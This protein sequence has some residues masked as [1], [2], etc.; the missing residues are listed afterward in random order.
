[1]DKSTYQ[2]PEIYR[3]LQ[4]S[5]FNSVLTVA[6]CGSKSITNRALLLATLAEGE[7]TLRGALFSDDSRH[8]LKCI[9]DLGFESTAD[10]KAR[11]ITVKGCGGRVPLEKANQYVGSAG[12][13]ARFLTAY[14]GVSE[15]SYY[16]DASKQMRKR[17]MAPLLDSLRELGCEIIYEDT[18]HEGFFPFT[19]RGHGFGKNEITVDIAHSSQFLS[20]LLIASCL[21]KE[22]FTTYIE[23]THGRS[24]IDM[25]VK[26]MEQF[27]VKATPLFFCGG[28]SDNHSCTGCINSTLPMGYRTAAGQS[29]RALDYRIEPD[30]SAA[31]YFYAMSP[32]LGISVQVSHVHFNSLQGDVAF[33]RLLEKMGCK[34]ADL[35]DGI[36]VEPPADGVFH[37]ITADLSAYS[38][39]AITLAAIAPYADSPTTI[40]GIGHIRFQESDRITAMITELRRMGI[41]CEE[42]ES[43]ITI[44]PAQP[45]AALIETYDDHR[46][47]MG[48][49]LTGLRASGIVIDNPGCCKKTFEEYFD[50]LDQVV[51]ELRGGLLCLSI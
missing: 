27:G 31:C 48:F 24:Y 33:I 13:A 43:S 9:Q 15:G 30:V 25:T 5:P 29:Y 2:V 11:Q 17:P 1:M 46:M 40:T 35:E 26:M 12:T 36:L 21:S 51:R 50:V 7:S 20:A 44:Y 45:K 4:A 34:A 23:G 8:F 38:D 32:L 16:M 41:R 47:A 6:V 19:L 18:G 22:T 37:G 42:T 3:A 14:L 28:N 49:S 39:Q 10:E